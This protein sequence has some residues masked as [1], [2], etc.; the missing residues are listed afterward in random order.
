M[1]LTRYEYGLLAI[2][3]P[4]IIMHSSR[5]TLVRKAGGEAVLGRSWPD[6]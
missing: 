3:R 1:V 6:D 2:G 4:I 5:Q